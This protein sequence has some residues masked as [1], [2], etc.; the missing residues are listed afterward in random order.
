MSLDLT[1]I[2]LWIE[3]SKQIMKEKNINI[4]KLKNIFN[5]IFFPWNGKYDL[6]RNYYSL[7]IQQRPLFIIRP[8][9][10]TEVEYILNYVYKKNLK[11]LI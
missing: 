7:R 10:I 2:E 9:T 6:Y 4:S 11:M 8:I 1:T 3:K 5:H